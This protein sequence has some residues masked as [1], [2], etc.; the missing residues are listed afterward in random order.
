MGV[1]DF[2]KLLQLVP[3]A[4]KTLEYRQCSGQIWAI[5]ASIFCYRFSHNRDAKGPNSH[6]DKFYQ[7]FLRMLKN[8][9]QPVLVLDGRAPP[10]KAH[11]IQARKAQRRQNIAKVGE[12]AQDLFEMA[13]VDVQLVPAQMDSKIMDETVKKIT[14]EQFVTEYQGTPL[15]SQMKAKVE[16]IKK[17]SKNIITFNPHLEED[18]YQLCSLLN[19]PVL[20]AEGEADSVCAKLYRDKMIHAVVS[21]DSDMLFYG[22]GRLLSKFSWLESFEEINLSVLLSGLGITYQQF[23]DLCILCGT[24]YTPSTITGIG[25]SRA[26][27]YIRAGMPIETLIDR[28]TAG[29][30]A[31]YRHYRVPES[32]DFDYKSVRQLVSADTRYVARI[33]ALRRYDPQTVD[34]KSLSTWLMSKRNY[35]LTTLQNHYTQICGAGPVFTQPGPKRLIA[36]AL[37]KK[38]PESAGAGAGAGATSIETTSAP[39]PGLEDKPKTKLILTR[40]EAPKLS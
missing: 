38:Q 16:Q 13:G 9:I 12:L 37:K 35:R 30:E 18:L 28:I 29:V 20:Q 27:S 25:P 22:V 3:Q 23:I 2:R 4:V 6:V 31:E 14:L 7:L 8:G 11:T 17:A 10:Q 33:G 21:E 40:K 19:I 24:D 26:L 1:S 39:V 32:G 5:D 15:E 36:L 34:F